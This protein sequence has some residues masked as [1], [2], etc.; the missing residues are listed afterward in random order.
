MSNTSKICLTI[1][2]V[3]FLAAMIVSEVSERNFKLKIEQLE[4]Q[5]TT[6]APVEN[7]GGIKVQDHSIVL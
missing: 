4:Q 7:V 3:A 2:A 1:I 6:P 5:Q